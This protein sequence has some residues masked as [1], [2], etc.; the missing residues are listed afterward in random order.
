MKPIDQ[1]NFD[2]DYELV[3]N[4]PIAVIHDNA[5]EILRRIYKIRPI[6]KD[7]FLYKKRK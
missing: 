5:P 3:K 4:Y 1:K 6:G 7:Y 2:G